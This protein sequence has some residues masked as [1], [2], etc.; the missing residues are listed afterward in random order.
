MLPGLNEHAFD[1]SGVLPPDAWYAALLEG[2]FNITAQPSVLEAVA[3]AGYAV[4]V[5]V[6]FLLPAV[7][8]RA[9]SAERVRDTA[10]NFPATGRD[11][12]LLTGPILNALARR[13]MRTTPTTARLVAAGALALAAL[14]ACGGDSGGGTAATA[15]APP[16][17][18]SPCRRPTPPARS[19]PPRLPAGTATFAVTNNGRR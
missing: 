8:A 12:H 7:P 9:A 3:W 2:M 14:T 1:I 11:H 19:P 15:G 4:P 5:L 18:R 16:P 17:A 10:A 13:T 6:L